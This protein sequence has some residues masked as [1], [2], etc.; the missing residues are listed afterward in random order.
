MA[1]MARC[2]LPHTWTAAYR[3]NIYLHWKVSAPNCFRLK[4]CLFAFAFVLKS[5][6]FAFAVVLLL[7]MLNQTVFVILL[8]ADLIFFLLYFY[9]LCLTNIF[10]QFYSATQS[11][12]AEVGG[13]WDKNES[14]VTPQEGFMLTDKI[15]VTTVTYYGNSS[16]VKVP[17]EDNWSCIVTGQYGSGSHGARGYYLGVLRVPPDPY[18]K[19]CM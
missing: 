13:W 11:T 7:I 1:S 5:C 6:L 16:N 17:A 15:T 14:M 18:P 10:I 3:K 4:S 19:P 8:F 9:W 12:L 2:T